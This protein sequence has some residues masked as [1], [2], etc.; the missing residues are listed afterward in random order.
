LRVIDRRAGAMLA[1]G[2]TSPCINICKMEG[3]FCLGCLRSLDE[4]ARWATADD[5]D[6]RRI[7]VAVAQRRTRLAPASP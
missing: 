1:V 3:D 2:V 6:K 7:L 4:I 5:D